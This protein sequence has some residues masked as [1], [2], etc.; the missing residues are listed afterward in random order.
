MKKKFIFGKKSSDISKIKNN[1]IP[2]NDR[3]IKWQKKLFNIYKKEK[4]RNKCKNCDKKIGS[5][6]FTKTHK[7]FSW[8]FFAR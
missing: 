1:F 6:V 4:N 3:L 8:K 7:C 2:E 5:K